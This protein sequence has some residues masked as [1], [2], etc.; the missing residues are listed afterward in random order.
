MSDLR[1][2]RVIAL[3]DEAN[4]CDPETVEVSGGERPAAF[5]YGKRMSATLEH[6][7]PGASDHLQIAVRGQHI[8][9]W[10][11]PRSTYAEGRTG[12]LKWRKDL[13]AFHAKR[14]AE[15]MEKSGYHEMDIERVS[16]LVRKAGLKTDPEVQTL[17]D[18][19]CLVF[20]EHHAADLFERYEDDKVVDILEKTARKMSAEGLAAAGRL[21]LGERLSRLM[22][23][24]L[25]G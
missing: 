8:E 17:E 25:A 2:S 3:I 20:L 5:V 22:D 16:R 13:Q 12:Y 15:L 14:L 18:V 21:E 7:A 9:R 4:S 10:T 6:L 1:L 23:R 11:V 19:A 24:A